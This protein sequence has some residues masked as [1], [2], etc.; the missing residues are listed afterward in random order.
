MNIIKRWNS[1]TPKFFKTL[2]NVGLALTA[3]GAT[4][5][6]APV[7]LP[8]AVITAAGY[9]VVAGSVMTAVSQAVVDGEKGEG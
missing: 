9:V 3:A 7:L 6:A 5:L 8:A 2:R 1:K 4:V